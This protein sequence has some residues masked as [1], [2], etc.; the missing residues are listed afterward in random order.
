MSAR[1]WLLFAAV[2]LVAL[3][4]IVLSHSTSS[5]EEADDEPPPE[6]AEPTSARPVTT[7]VISPEQSRFHL[8]ADAARAVCGHPLRGPW[9]RTTGLDAII[10]GTHVPC[11]SCVALRATH[12]QFDQAVTVAGRRRPAVPRPVPDPSTWRTDQLPLITAYVQ[13]ANRT[14]PHHHRT[15][16]PTARAAR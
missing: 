15:E 5:H 7:W 3:V 12:R 14:A 8:S 2:V 9:V 13:A 6:A 4:G 1:E 10:P 16:P 11:D